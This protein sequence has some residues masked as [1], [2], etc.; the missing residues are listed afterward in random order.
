MESIALDQL[1]TIEYTSEFPAPG[2][3]IDEAAAINDIDKII[4]SAQ[5]KNEV[6]IRRC[7]T[8]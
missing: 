6:I 1:W 5:G 3:D 2:Q 8:W 7:T 4:A